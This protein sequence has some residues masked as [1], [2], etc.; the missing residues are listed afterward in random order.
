MSVDSAKFRATGLSTALA[1]LGGV[2][3]SM[4]LFWQVALALG[5][6]EI[7][8]SSPG[9]V[10]GVLFFSLLGIA[11]M[12][13]SIRIN[14]CGV[15]FDKNVLTTREITRTRHFARSEVIRGEI[16][17][18]IG[19]L[20]PDLLLRIQLTRGRTA[21]VHLYGPYTIWRRRSEEIATFLNEW[22]ES[23]NRAPDP[24]GSAVERFLQHRSIDPSI[25]SE[26][27]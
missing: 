6:H 13:A 20:R 23:R 18:Q 1:S 8:V 17:R 24:E 21:K 25:Q 2:T 11:G 15:F 4:A 9:E 7:E 16:V 19:F 10:G 27:P 3:L 12:I 22:V 14:F 5:G 26:G